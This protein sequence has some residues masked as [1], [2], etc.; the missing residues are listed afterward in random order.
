M[1]LIYYQCAIC[2]NGDRGRIMSTGRVVY[3]SDTQRYFS[4]GSGCKTY[5]CTGCGYAESYIDLEY[6][7]E[8]KSK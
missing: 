1:Q 3:K 6:L 4:A 8:I 7:H 2:K 5:V